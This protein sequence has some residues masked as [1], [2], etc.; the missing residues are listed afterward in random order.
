MDMLVAD[1][2]ESSMCAPMEDENSYQYIKELVHEIANQ[3]RC[4]EDLEELYD[5]KC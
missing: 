5:E 2:L 3:W 4:D 1:L